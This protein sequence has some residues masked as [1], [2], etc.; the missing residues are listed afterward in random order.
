[1][2]TTQPVP[3]AICYDVEDIIAPESDDAVLWLA[4]ILHAHDL[5]GSFMIVGEKARLWER[6]G[7]RDVIEALK[8]HHLSYHS[9]WHSVHPTTTE[10]CLDKSFAEGMDALWEWD[11][12]GWSDAE[13]ILG[14]PL[15][16]WARTGSSWSPSVMGLMGLMGRGYAYSLVRLP[17][18][19]VCWYANCLGFYG[20]G[21]G[22]FD[23]VLYED[24]L[25]TKQFEFVQREVDRFLAEPHA[26]ATWL[27]WF[28][29]H[30]TRFIS[31]DFWD[32]V[33][34]AKGANPPPAEWKPAPQHDPS[35][36]PLMQKN[37]HQVCEFLR[38]DRRLEVV[39][40]G[41]LLRRYDGQR[42]SASHAEL[43]EIAHQIADTREVLF[44]DFF[45]AAEI[46]WMLC[47]AVTTPQERYARPHLY[48]PLTR[49]PVS[50]VTT[51]PGDAI[52][53]AA[54]GVLAATRSGFLPATVAVGGEG[55]GIGTYFIALAQAFLGQE[56]ISAPADAPYPPVAEAVAEHAGESI[57]GWI[58][59]P[60][61]MDLTNLLEQ[62][63]LQC[64]ALKPAW[65]R[66]HLFGQP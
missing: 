28:M 15:L 24:A 16:G 48:G 10:I 8:K 17:G 14:R 29:G 56:T 18:H 9:T 55:I 20:E 34:F 33:N 58:I 62:T 44:T 45:T 43:T 38:Q 11:R 60:D 46:L 22:G 1:M 19:N 64:W 26:G 30:P 50:T 40:W 59:H 25:F 42:P 37:Y 3:T 13:R 23:E 35:L 36:I 52:L 54:A 57:P 21:I 61:N 6:R 63:R 31:T 66:N 32:G 47:Q 5:T 65:E 41:D 53:Q 49:P 39:G 4:E 51:W 27:C 2:S 7:R 12:Q